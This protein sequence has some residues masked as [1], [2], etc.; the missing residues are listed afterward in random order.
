MS[1]LFTFFFFCLTVVGACC[2]NLINLE[3][4]T[5]R[6]TISCT[7]PL[8]PS[9]N[10]NTRL[11]KRSFEQSHPHR[12]SQEEH[13]KQIEIVLLQKMTC[14]RRARQKKLYIDAYFSLYGFDSVPAGRASLSAW[15]HYR[16]KQ[17]SRSTCMTAI[18]SKESA[19]TRETERKRKRERGREREKKGMI[20][21]N[22]QE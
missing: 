7:A 11:L 13:C 14:S 8:L 19:R 22:R 21:K 9:T 3:F 4:V 17:S 18:P 20:K 6:E 16:F 2:K 10:F 12:H 15:H 5:K 1:V